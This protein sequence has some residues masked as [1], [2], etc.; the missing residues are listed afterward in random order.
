MYGNAILIERS[1]TREGGSSYKLKA[2]GGRLVSNRKEELDEICD[3]MGIQVDNPMNV[4]TQDAARQFLQNS[5]EAQKYKFFLKGVQL[6]Q[7]NQD[8]RLLVD[9][10]TNTEAT[11]VTKSAHLL[12]LKK[13]YDEAVRKVKICRDHE[14]L[15][16]KIG[17]YNSQVGW[18][19]VAAYE[20]VSIH[21]SVPHL[22]IPDCLLVRRRS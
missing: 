19:Q 11:L 6:E 12:E 20:H 2:S 5:T 14:Q 10:I 16:K 1:F 9:S 3:Y 4:L 18:A 17:D 15:V 7:L 22:Y 13:A 8:Y 21:P